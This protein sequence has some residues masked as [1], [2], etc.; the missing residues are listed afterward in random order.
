MHHDLRLP[1]P[2]PGPTA[3]SFPD[4][5]RVNYFHG[6]LLGAR[7]FRA[8]QAYHRAKHLL[9]N[10]CMFGYGVVCGLEVEVEPLPQD[11]LDPREEAYRKLEAELAE[12]DRAVAAAV[13]EVK[14]A[15]EDGGRQRAAKEALGAAEARAE[16]LKRRHE[17][18]CAKLP[19]A[20]RRAPLPLTL[21][22]GAGLAIDPQGHEL[23]VRQGIRIDLR[24]HLSPEDRAKIERDGCGTVWLSLCYEE[25]GFERVTVPAMDACQIMPGC[26]DAR[27]RE[28]VRL[29]A[30]LEEPDANER[31]EPCCESSCE[32]CVLLAAIEVTDGRPLRPDDLDVSVRRPFGLYTPTVITG[33]NWRHGGSYAAASARDL[34]GRRNS[35]GLEL[36]FSR[37]VH[38]ETVTPG[39]M[40]VRILRGGRGYAG[41][42]QWIQGGFLPPDGTGLVDRIHWRASTDETPQPDDRILII[43]RCDFILDACCRPVDGNHVG[44]RVPEIAGGGRRRVVALLEDARGDRAGAAGRDPARPLPGTGDGRPEGATVGDGKVPPCARMPEHRG[45]WTSGNGQP[46]GSFESWIFI[47]PESEEAAR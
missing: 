17:A 2:R 25:C 15:G 22:I 24:D 47:Q 20:P 4:F 38:A 31:C 11:C 27:I 9:I 46:G 26:S 12:A 40:D 39:V 16:E 6:Q 36:R 21:R 13:E 32:T 10:R 33:I 43:L 42:I 8:E 14:R 23:V 44:G 28:G 1:L 35:G 18:E 34:L 3:D 29:K 45:P 5:I 7:D 41:G 30:G 19:R 37:K